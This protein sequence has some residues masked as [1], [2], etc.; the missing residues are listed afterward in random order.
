MFEEGWEVQMEMRSDMAS[1]CPMNLGVFRGGFFR[2][3]NVLVDPIDIKRCI[4]SNKR[5]M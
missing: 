3:R 1:A 5:S 2:A 4:I